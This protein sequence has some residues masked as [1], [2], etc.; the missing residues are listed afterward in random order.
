M[1]WPPGWLPEQFGSGPKGPG[2]RVGEELRIRVI[3][4]V[5]DLASRIQCLE[6]VISRI[7][8]AGLDYASELRRAGLKKLDLM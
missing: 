4:S 7:P 1:L 3:P 5:E 8:I 6:R 2:V